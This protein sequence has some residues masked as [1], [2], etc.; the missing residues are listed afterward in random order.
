MRRHRSALSKAV[1][2]RMASVA[3][4]GRGNGTVYVLLGGHRYV[5]NVLAGHRRVHL[6][7]TVPG[8]FGPFAGDEELQVFSHVRKG[9]PVSTWRDVTIGPGENP[10]AWV[11]IW[12]CG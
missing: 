6:V 2:W 11:I 9:S 8:P 7:V 12:L 5:V 3:S 4:R 10:I 1:Q